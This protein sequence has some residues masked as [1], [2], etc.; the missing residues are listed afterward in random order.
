MAFLFTSYINNIDHSSSVAGKW[1]GNETRRADINY[2]T[3]DYLLI[4]GILFHYQE[5]CYH[6]LLYL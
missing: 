6:Y 2:I 1:I 4:S 5:K 3:I